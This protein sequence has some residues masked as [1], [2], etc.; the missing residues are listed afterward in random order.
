[1]APDNQRLPERRETLTAY[2]YLA[3]AGLILLIFWFVP[4]VGALGISFTNWEGADTLDLV[5]HAGVVGTKA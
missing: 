2:M 1:M 4:F 5:Q 3:P